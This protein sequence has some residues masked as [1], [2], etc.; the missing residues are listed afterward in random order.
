VYN[1][2]IL[3]YKGFTVYGLASLFKDIVSS[4]ET[5]SCL[6]P[7][8]EWKKRQGTVDSRSG[9]VGA[10]LR[11]CVDSVDLC[12]VV[13]HVVLWTGLSATLLGNCSWLLKQDTN[14]TKHEQRL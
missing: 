6:R 14:R 12:F 8:Q 4:C 7:I 5:R 11:A 9:S 2:G 1:I 3:I 13:A 10:C